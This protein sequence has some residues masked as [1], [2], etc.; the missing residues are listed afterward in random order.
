VAHLRERGADFGNAVHLREAP[1]VDGIDVLALRRKSRVRSSGIIAVIETWDQ[2]LVQRGDLAGLPRGPPIPPSGSRLPQA[3]DA[4]RCLS[5]GA[6]NP[7][8]GPR[9]HHSLSATLARADVQPEPRRLRRW[10]ATEHV[11][12]GG[13]GRR[14]AIAGSSH[15]LLI[16]G[17]APFSNEQHGACGYGVGCAADLSPGCAF[18]SRRS[19]SNALV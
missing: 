8:K 14:T 17:A 11:L 12:V 1:D 18:R 2:M 4:R 3:S 10:Q 9:T 13:V 7:H 16:G 19:R 5:G 15:S 6:Q